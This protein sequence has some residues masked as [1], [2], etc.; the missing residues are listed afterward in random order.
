MMNA[1]RTEY[2]NPKA[3]MCQNNQMNSANVNTEEENE[4]KQRSLEE[5]RKSI[6]NSLLLLKATSKDSV[7]SEESIKLLEK[8]LEEL[9]SQIKA[10][11]KDTA[12]ISAEDGKAIQE[13]RE[14]MIRNRFD[15]YVKGE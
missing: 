2:V 4:K 6:Q 1:L 10:V 9:E 11:E 7:G 14:F 15:V 13:N 5:E 3:V 12:E 8:Q